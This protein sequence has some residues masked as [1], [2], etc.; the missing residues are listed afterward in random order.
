VPAYSVEDPVKV[1]GRDEVFRDD[2]NLGALRL[3][4]LLTAIEG[5]GGPILLLGC[6]AGRYA[7]A[8]KR[9][10]P[11]RAVV[12]G[13]LSLTALSEAVSAGQGPYYLA[14]DA[15]RLPFGDGTFGAVVFLDL[16]EHVPEPD[17]LLGECGRVLV[18]GGTL[19]YFLPLED[20]PGTLYRLLR[21]NRPI[22]I[23]SWKEKHVGHIQRF[24]R[25]DALRRTWRA[26]LPVTHTSYSFHLV[27]Q[28][29]DIVDYW[30]RERTSGEPGRLPVEW[31]SRIT[32]VIF[33]V[34]WRLSYLEDHLYHGAQFASGIHVTAQKAGTAR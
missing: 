21:N 13:D 26:G 17:L 32:R 34:T 8:I 27:G 19:H 28:L 5:S 10:L 4:R 11:D 29:H 12:G 3:D 20:E 23:H 33:V 22:P 7:R 14:L 9:E 15:Q 18:P 24:Q 16:L 25:G 6:G 1:Q 31:V 30:N 2:R